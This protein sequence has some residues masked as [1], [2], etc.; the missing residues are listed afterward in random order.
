MGKSI[1]KLMSVFHGRLPDKECEQALAD[2]AAHP[3]LWSAAHKVFDEVRGRLLSADEQKDGLRIA[4]YEFAEACCKALYNATGPMDEF[5]PSFRV[6]C[7]S[8]CASVG[9]E[10]RFIAVSPL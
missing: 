5:D 7:C 3:D 2:L 9:E 10:S 8:F 1:E 4:Q 6:L